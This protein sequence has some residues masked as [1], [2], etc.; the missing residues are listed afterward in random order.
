[1]GTPVKI[2]IEDG[3]R[4]VEILDISTD[5]SE[6]YRVALQESDAEFLYVVP[7]ASR[8]EDLVNSWL[9]FPSFQFGPLSLRAT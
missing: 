1:M 9:S 5:T 3:G 6:G 4:T 8:V 7:L 2:T